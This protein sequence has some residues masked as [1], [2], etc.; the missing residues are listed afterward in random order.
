MQWTLNYYYRGVC[1]WSWYYPH[2]YAPYISDIKNFKDFQF[3]FSLGK[4][5]LPFEQLLSVLPAASKE[6]LPIAYHQ[7]MTDPNS[8]IIDYYP[9]NFETDLNGKKQEWEALVLIPFINEN[10]LMGAM[11]ECN[12]N[13]TESEK[14]RNKHGPMLQYDHCDEDQ[15]SLPEFLAQPMIA[16]IFCKTTQI[17]RAEILVSEDKMIFGPCAGASVDVYFPGFPTMRH[18]KH[19]VFYP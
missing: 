3:D 6:L 12:D 16:H 4:P 15:G 18:L 10:R 7:L 9:E 19:S 5:F 14:Y 11:N 13:L 8:K 17:N 1:S 2:H